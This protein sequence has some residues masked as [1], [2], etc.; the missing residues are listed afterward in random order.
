ML[1]IPGVINTLQK[2]IKRQR[3]D[4]QNL[5]PKRAQSCQIF[6]STVAVEVDVPLVAVAARLPPDFLASASSA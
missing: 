5:R 3:N 1:S 4:A 2:Q 6:L